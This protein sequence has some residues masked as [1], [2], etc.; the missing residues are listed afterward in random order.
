MDFV[1]KMKCSD[2]DARFCSYDCKKEYQ[3][4]DYAFE[5]LQDRAWGL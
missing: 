4:N 3:V 1:D 2:W 5:V